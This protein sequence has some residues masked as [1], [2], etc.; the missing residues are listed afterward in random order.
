MTLDNVIGLPM[1]V[2]PEEGTVEHKGWLRGYIID[3]Y[4]HIKQFTGDTV[5]TENYLNL[6]NMYREL[7][8]EVWIGTYQR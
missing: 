4:D 5:A 1:G 8:A 7:Y 3:A 6:M 2:I